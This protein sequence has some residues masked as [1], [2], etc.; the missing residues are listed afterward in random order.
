[1]DYRRRI[2]VAR[3]RMVERGLDV[4]LIGRPANRAYLSGFTGH[5]D[6]A[7][8]S[9]GW[10]VLSASTGHFLTSFNY[11]DVVQRTMRD[12]EPVRAE[13]RM[14][15]SLIDLLKKVS[16]RKIGFEGNWVTVELY[17]ALAEGLGAER[18]LVRADGINEA[19]RE[20]KD[21]EELERIRCAVAL[22]DRAFEDISA[23]I[24]PGQTERQVA[25]A[26]EKRLRELGADE[27]AFGPVVASGPN[28]AVPHHES[29]D[30]VILAGEPIWIDLGA[31][32][33]GYCG[34]LT[35]SF[36]LESASD[37][38]LEAWD[39][40]LRAEEAAIERIRPGLSG[41]E[42]DAIARDLLAPEEPR[43]AFGHGL[44]HG[45]G[46][47]IHEG[48]WILPTIEDAIPA[49]SIVTI[50][51]GLYESGWGGIRHE[52]AVLLRPEGNEVLSRAKKAPILR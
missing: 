24:R 48:P 11:F 41:K 44:G 13:G 52:D 18:Q 50:E 7:M 29:S 17:E 43:R 22:T 8:R 47:E 32:L 46:L 26:I 27:M 5:D 35:R 4:L 12:L 3:E 14:V 33:E 37:A 36:C 21:G 30:R 10:V 39:R 20:A 49:N 25:W 23:S 15:T 2:A 40:V 19:A 51:P 31:R 9:S 45:I 28:A 16:G 42:A 1:M 38:Y 34:D 6:S